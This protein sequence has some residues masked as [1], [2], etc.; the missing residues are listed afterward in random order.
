MSPQI[1]SRGLIVNQS[2]ES[3]TLTALF[4]QE[5]DVINIGLDRF[6]EDLSAQGVS[7][8]HLDWKPPANGDPELAD[9]LSKLGA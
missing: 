4:E 5:L 7:V 8:T 9:L 6:A 2:K 1:I 3:E